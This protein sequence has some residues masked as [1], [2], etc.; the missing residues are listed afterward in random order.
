[1]PAEVVRND[2][3]QSQR[4]PSEWHDQEAHV[5]FPRHDQEEPS[6]HHSPLDRI[7]IDTHVAVCHEKC[8]CSPEQGTQSVLPNN[9]IPYPAAFGIICGYQRKKLDPCWITGVRAPN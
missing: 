1:M 8:T 2:I 5:K 9:K 3:L 6:P 4:K 7:H